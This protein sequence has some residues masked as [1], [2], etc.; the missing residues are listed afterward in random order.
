[1]YWR[2]RM[3]IG[4]TIGLAVLAFL[5]CSSCAWAEGKLVG[6]VVESMHAGSYTYVRVET[7]GTTQWVAVP[8]VVVRKG[9]VVEFA[10]GKAMGNFTSPTNGR[11]FENIIFS[12]GVINR[13]Q[14]AMARKAGGDL[15]GLQTV[16]VVKAVGSDGRTIAEIFA[17][18]AA[19]DGKMVVVRGKVVKFS[20]YADRIWLRLVD[21]SGSSKRG[22]H[23][24]V[25][26][27]KQTTAQ[28]GNIVLVSGN[29]HADKSF[30]SLVYE[31]V[32]EDAKVIVETK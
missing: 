27:C 10:P 28:K 4:V 9:D 5:L 14:G 21:G 30:G 24:L 31:V 23:K 22:N 32:V 7:G 20:Q 26:V 12:S 6:K 17:Q 11:S 8:R 29:M 25:V 15:P 19:L 2:W 13:R 16:H 3:K 18:K 1:M